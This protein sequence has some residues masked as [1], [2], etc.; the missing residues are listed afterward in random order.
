MGSEFEARSLL[1]GEFAREVIGVPSLLRLISR[2]VAL[3]TMLPTFHK[4]DYCIVCCIFNNIP[5]C[6]SD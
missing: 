4:E 3:A 1:V 6:I 5:I 2:A